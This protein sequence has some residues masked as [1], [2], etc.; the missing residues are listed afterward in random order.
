MNI[1]ITGAA[2]GI[3]R[4]VAERFAKD[5]HRVF[6]LDLNAALDG[7]EITYYTVDVTSEESVNRVKDEISGTGARLDAIICVAGV[8][9][10]A[11]LVEE[12]YQKLK[13][14]IDV[15]LLGAML[16]CRTFHPL[17]HER[18]RI[19]IVT[20]EVAS[21]SPLP[22][23]GLYNLSKVALDSYAEALRQELNL[24]GQ[25]VITV[26]PGAVRT[27]LEASS[28]K[29]TEALAEKT[30]LYNKQA[31]HFTHFVE[32]FTGKPI[33]PEKVAEIIYKAATKKH[34]KVAYSI[35]R[36]P[37]LVLLSLLP[38][39]LQCFIIKALLNR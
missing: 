24:I 28:I 39:S 26:R 29:S 35:N 19:V 5:S 14:V 31:K 13:R 25:K 22:F 32:K 11:S 27:P 16:V 37:G 7:E 9:A 33:V 30:V 3:G 38:H 34:P 4:A 36:H 18:G 17:L 8:H 20:S 21:Y 15:N 23:N 6:G 10:M 1:L 12:D 2:S